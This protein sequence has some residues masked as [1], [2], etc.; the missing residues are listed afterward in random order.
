MNPL[1]DKPFSEFVYE[2]RRS[3][4][5]TQKDASDYLQKRINQATI[6]RWESPEKSTPPP[7][8]Y[9]ALLALLQVE[10]H[11]NERPE[12]NQDSLLANLNYYIGQDYPHLKT[13]RNWR[14]LEQSGIAFAGEKGIRLIPEAERAYL[15]HLK[16]RIL[17][18]LERREHIV[19]LYGDLETH[20]PYEETLTLS[21]GLAANGLTD[22]NENDNFQNNTLEKVV[23]GKNQVIVLGAPGAGKTT[24]LLKLTLQTI[25]EYLSGSVEHPRLPLFA[26]LKAYFTRFEQIEDFLES[27][28]G[29]YL[30]ESSYIL[31]ENFQKSLKEA[32]RWLIILD[33]LNEL[34]GRKELLRN[35]DFLRS[36]RE[37]GLF[38]TLKGQVND[39]REEELLR[40]SKDYPN[41]KLVVSC[42]EHDYTMTLPWYKFRIIPL[43]AT[44]IKEFLYYY[45]GETEGEELY[46]QLQAKPELLTILSNPFY[47]R[48]FCWVCDPG[49]LD[50]P[51][52]T[53]ELMVALIVR[54]FI[55]EEIYTSP[56][57]FR[58]EELLK[59]LAKLSYDLMENG[60]FDPAILPEI[61]HQYLN[62]LQLTKALGTSLL[63]EER[64]DHNLHF[65]Y[66]HQIIQEFLTACH[67]ANLLS[68]LSELK[69]KRHY[70][71]ILAEFDTAQLNFGAYRLQF[72]WK[73]EKLKKSEYAFYQKLG[74]MEWNPVRHFV[75]DL[76]EDPFTFLYQLLKTDK[77][78]L[79]NMQVDRP[80]AGEVRGYLNKVKRL[81][82][83]QQQLLLE[84]AQKKI[85]Q[86]NLLERVSPKIREL[87]IEHQ[88]ESKVVQYPLLQL[89]KAAYRIEHG[90]VRATVIN[91]FNVLR[92]SEAALDA[93]LKMA[94]NM[95]ANTHWPIVK[96][97]AC[98]GSKRALPFLIREALG[99]NKDV[100]WQACS[101]LALLKDVRAVAPLMTL[102]EH[103]DKS[104]QFIAIYA[105]GEIGD[106]RPLERLRNHPYRESFEDPW[107]WWQQGNKNVIQVSIERIEAAMCGDKNDPY[108]QMKLYP[109]R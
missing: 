84:M 100:C 3:V 38:S 87:M 27:V 50:Y 74:T 33:G 42:R 105:L 12:K 17:E 53:T 37:N 29:D 39:P 25:E 55:R 40:L 8:G 45:R 106:P 101:G 48:T 68:D 88:I 86:P 78:W 51:Q 76:V 6:S 79:Y 91:A 31:R 9:L 93:L 18:A 109:W 52:T 96:S 95:D 94:E 62:E 65:G 24:S 10:R 19:P 85:D 90:A 83:S 43:F 5:P 23:S 54:L 49:A 11:S 16:E 63:L 1:S 14:T 30:D 20:Q 80:L 70:Q 22:E 64:S 21:R 92:G 81:T 4:F 7:L 36:V 15:K 47:L 77:G 61:L 46:Q 26:S 102:L 108:P 73:L 44:Q 58:H 32:G 75:F 99:E 41:C 59:Q 34:P 72:N 89:L 57:L 35:M 56:E 71:N 107:N 60:S 66:Y 98:I 104:R 67:I 103:P 28:L 97:V 82:P 2:L 13:F 69:N